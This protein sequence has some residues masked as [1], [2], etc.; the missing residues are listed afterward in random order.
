MGFFA[1][2]KYGATGVLAPDNSA[3]LAGLF[4]GGGTTVLAAQAVG[5]LIITVA[6]FVVSLVVMYAVNAMGL[7]RV[8]AEGENYGLD[9]HEHGIP[10]YPEYVIS[11]L[12][13]PAGTGTATHMA[14]AAAPS[15]VLSSQPAR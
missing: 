9:L 10:A 11:A 12:G 13:S 4:Y 14:T 7:L 5:S 8:S 2:G 6:T 15:T 1:C 3:P